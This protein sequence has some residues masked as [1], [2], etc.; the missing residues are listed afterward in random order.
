MVSKITLIVCPVA[1][2]MAEISL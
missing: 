1:S 2:Q